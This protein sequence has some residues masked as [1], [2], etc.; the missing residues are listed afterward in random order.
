MPVL[1]EAI[2]CWISLANSITHS[3][4]GEVAELAHAGKDSELQSFAASCGEKIAGFI[5]Q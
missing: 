2:L 1:E 5:K 4:R 3:K